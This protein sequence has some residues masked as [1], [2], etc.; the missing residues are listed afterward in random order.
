MA[1]GTFYPAA[2]GD[3]GYCDTDGTDYKPT[4]N[5]LLLGRTN[6]GAI[7]YIRFVSVTIPAGATI[8]TCFVRFTAFA[9]QSSNTVDINCYFE[10]ADN[11]AAPSSGADVIGRVKTSAV[12]AWDSIGAW[13]DGN[14][15][16]TPDLTTPLQE[17]IDRGGWSSGQAVMALLQDD[18]VDNFVSR[19]PSAYDYLS[20][21]EKAELHV[22]WETGI[23]VETSEGLGLSDE[24]DAFS[25]TDE[26]NEGLGLSDVMTAEGG[27]VFAETDEGLGLSDDSD[28]EFEGYPSISEGLGIGD[29]TISEL[30]LLGSISEGLGL[31]DESEAFNWTKWLDLNKDR[32]IER[33]Y[34]TLTGAADSTTDI[35]ID[36]S[37][38]QGRKKTGEQTYLSVV[39][40]EYAVNIGPISDRSNGQMVI[41]M[42]YLLNGEISVREEVLRVDLENIRDDEGIR[43]HPITLSGHITETFSPKVVTLYDTIYRNFSE[44]RILHRFAMPDLYLNPGDTCRIDDDE[45]EVD[46]IYYIVSDSYK[47]MEIREV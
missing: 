6:I 31:G 30:E 24:A 33:F 16:D 11:P 21:A 27:S 41:D 2:N 43:S 34:F 23:S 26:L 13:T 45:F 9:S 28:F 19:Q 44:G 38:F 4:N 18:G 29:E 37:S 17:V 22:T 25:L 1:S 36:I 15:Y 20:A 40:P 46:Y 42:A 3:D 12:V 5:N 14:T 32:A 10:D 8:L 35:E 47:M 39:I 7:N